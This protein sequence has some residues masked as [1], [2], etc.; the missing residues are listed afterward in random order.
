MNAPMPWPMTP[1][2]R[3]GTPP[4]LAHIELLDRDGAV[5]HRIPVTHWPISI[6]RAL[7]CEV[8]LDDPHAAAHHAVLQAPDGIPT[9]HLGPSP[10]GARLGKRRLAAGESTVISSG[11]DWTIGRT[12]LRLRLPTETLPPEVPLPTTTHVSARWLVLGVLA[13]VAWLLGEQ[14]IQSDPGDPVSGYLTV[15]VGVPASLAAWCFAW[16]LGSKLFTRQFD[17]P[18][19]LRWALSLLLITT[20]LDAVLPLLAFAASWEWLARLREL[21]PLAV[22]CWLV[23][24][25]LRLI[26]PARRHALMVGFATMFVVGTGL[27]LALQYQRTDRWFA[28]LYLSTLGP[29]ALRLA[30]TSDAATFIEGARKLQ[31]PLERRARDPDAPNAIGDDD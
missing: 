16:A 19:H 14:W 18:A 25:H 1:A 31:A 10:N 5:T 20:A 12:R 26:V 17:F 15:L 2:P 8:I 11:T 30:P 23:Y 4:L 24:G 28:P 6:G 27:K 29:P 7:D 13:L 3:E 21:L 9:L 22:G